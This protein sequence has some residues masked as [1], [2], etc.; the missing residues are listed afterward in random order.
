MV[1]HIVVAKSS[2]SKSDPDALREVYRMLEES[3]KASGEPAPKDGIDKH[4]IGYSA[5]K[6]NFEVAADYAWKQ[7]IIA[8]P[9]TLEDIFDATTRTL[10]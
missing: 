7:R 4:P 10:D 5:N 2:L 6:R 1:N 9:L 8:R 3:F